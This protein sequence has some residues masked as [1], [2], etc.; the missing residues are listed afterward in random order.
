[1]IAYFRQLSMRGKVMVIALVLVAGSGV[2]LGAARY[3]QRAPTIPT[4]EMKRA[5]FLDSLQLRGDVKA[6]KSITISAPAEAGDI[7]ILK[8]IPDGTVVKQGDVVVEFDKTKTEQDLALYRSTLKSSQAEI[9]QAKAQTRLVEEADQTALMKARYDVEAAKLDASKQEIVSRIDGEEAKLKL[10][11]AEQR[12]HEAEEKLKADKALNRSS[13]E[14]KDHAS[15]KAVYDVHRAEQSLT[16]MKLKAP[17][18]GMISILQHWRNDGMTQ[19]K[20]GDRAWPGAG[21]AELPEPSSL[22]ISAR[23]DET[24]RGRLALNQAV[25]VQFDAIPDRQLT[26]HVERISTIAD[27]DFS[28]GWPFP[29]NFIMEVVLDQTDPRLKPGMTAQLTVVVDRIPNALAVPVQAVFQKSGRDVVYVW[30]GTQFEERAVEFGKRSGDRVLV[31]KGLSP[32]E[33]VALTDPSA[34]E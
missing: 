28:E 29:R 20:A 14:G 10:A 5:E 7:E 11:D 2:V 24:E 12:L 17:S 3:R 19:F 34:K 25:D 18:A 15:A 30:R 33:R 26:G 23:V 1:M 22:Q 9:E 13:I 27:L 31:A 32:G 8:I 21:L 16:L 6:S 4:I